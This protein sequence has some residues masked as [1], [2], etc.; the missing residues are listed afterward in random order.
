[1]TSST[2]NCKSQASTPLVA[3][4]DFGTFGTGCGVSAKHEFQN[5]PIK[6]MTFQWGRLT[7]Q[8][9]SLKTPT[10]LLLDSHQKFVAFGYEAENMYCE[11]GLDGD[12]KDYYYFRCSKLFNYLVS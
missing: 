10:V 11:L 12:Q 4:I 7:Q 3:A 6:V 2:R 5:D 8:T 1:M 9:M